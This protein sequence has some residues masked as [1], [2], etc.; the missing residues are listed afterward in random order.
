[1]R[2]LQQPTS[3]REKLFQETRL[4]PEL[5][6]HKKKQRKR[7]RK[8]ESTQLI[9]CLVILSK[10]DPRSILTFLVDSGASKHMSDQRSFFSTFRPM[11]AGTWSV[12]GN[13]FFFSSSFIFKTNFFSHPD[14]PGIGDSELDALG[15]GN[16]DVLVEVDKVTTSKTLTEVLYVPGL[17]SNLFSVGAATANGLVATFDDNKVII[18]HAAFLIKLLKASFFFSLS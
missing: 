4:P 10:L 1:M 18:F 3:R 16:I 12:K 13:I 9:K 8:G 6:Q 5:V 15:I 7:Q 17:G 2:Y 14:L 11:N